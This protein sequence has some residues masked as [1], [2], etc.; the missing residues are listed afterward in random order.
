MR[1]FTIT[2]EVKAGS[3][4]REIA[5]KPDGSVLVRTTVAPERGK[6]NADVVDILAEHFGVPK[7]CVE[8][9]KGT[10]NKRKTFKIT[11]Q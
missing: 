1:V 2:V 8:L 4:R 11:A 5:V 10:T 9:L 3:R 7:T 6:A